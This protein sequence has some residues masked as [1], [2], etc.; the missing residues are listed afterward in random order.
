MEDDVA[1]IAQYQSLPEVY[2]ATLA[3][4]GESLDWAV[5]SAGRRRLRCVRTWHAGGGAEEF[6]TLTAVIGFE[7]GEGLP[8]SVLAI[9][10]RP[11]WWTHRPN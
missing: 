6:E 4:I 5:R 3:A 10:D 7:A 9:K 8:G 1:R 11:G 2:D